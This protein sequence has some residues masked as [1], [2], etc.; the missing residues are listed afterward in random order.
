MHSSR[1]VQ[2]PLGQVDDDVRAIRLLHEAG[3]KGD[4]HGVAAAFDLHV[5]QI[6]GA[7]I[8]DVDDLAKHRSA[9]RAPRR[10]PMRSAT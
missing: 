2:E 3:G 9:G 10:R 7:V 8:G 1:V 4:Q 6:A 5:D